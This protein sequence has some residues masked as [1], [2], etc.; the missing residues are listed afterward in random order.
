MLF[1]IVFL[2]QAISLGLKVRESGCSAKVSKEA[3]NPM[4]V[5]L[6]RCL[7]S[8]PHLYV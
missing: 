8:S 1:Q 5:N 7:C 3:L 6:R 4:L 2:M